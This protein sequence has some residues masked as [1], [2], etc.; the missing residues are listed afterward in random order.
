MARLH[1]RMPV[2]LPNREAELAWLDDGVSAA[3][4]QAL[5]RPYP[6]EQMQ[7]YTVSTLVNSP[8]HNAPDVLE[9]A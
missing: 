2:M 8:A 4:H 7:E 5:L 3:D 1:N 9:A 6:A